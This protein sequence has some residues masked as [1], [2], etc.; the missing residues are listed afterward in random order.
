MKAVRQMDL[1]D[2]AEERLR[3]SAEVDRMV[4]TTML[5]LEMEKARAD[6][7][8][9]MAQRAYAL[10]RARATADL[11]GAAA[12]DFSGYSDDAINKIIGVPGSPVSNGASPASPNDVGVELDLGGGFFDSIDG[13]QSSGDFLSTAAEG[14]PNPATDLSEP[15]Y[16]VSNSPDETSA[17]VNSGA[18]QLPQA[19]P[20]ELSQIKAL[21]KSGD[22]TA[23]QY[24]NPLSEFKTPQEKKNPL[25]DFDAAPESAIENTLKENANAFAGPRPQKKPQENEGGVGAYLVGQVGHLQSLPDRARGL[26]GLEK[27]R[28]LKAGDEFEQRTYATTA[29][30]LGLPPA[31]G[32]NAANA[33]AY[34]TNGSQRS[35]KQI[36]EIVSLFKESQGT[37]DLLEAAAIVD[38]KSKQRIDAALGKG[39]AASDPGKDLGQLADNHKKA[40]ESFA[41]ATASGDERAI[42]RAKSLLELQE[43]QLNAA[44]GGKF[45]RDTHAGIQQNFATAMPHLNNPK[46]NYKGVAYDQVDKSKPQDNLSS[47][48][49]FVQAITEGRMPTF[50]VGSDGRPNLD[51]ADNFLKY[52]GVENTTVASY[53]KDG[54]LGLFNYNPTG[55][56]KLTAIQTKAPQPTGGEK[57]APAEG[58]PFRA[59]A[60]ESQIAKGTQDLDDEIYKIQVEMTSLAKQRESLSTPVK[61][62]FLGREFRSA[63]EEVPFGEFFNYKRETMPERD[64]EWSANQYDEIT[65]KMRELA[66]EKSEILAKRRAIKNK[67]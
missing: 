8:L 4:K 64:P 46:V 54:S 17:S 23:E 52:Y 10:S 22:K 30:M 21:A 44:T 42:A 60:E 26:K 9:T 32:A 6:I 51:A 38:G 15:N 1:D 58:N 34:G 50:T 45:R 33:L 37:M 19:G 67:K 13:R 2:A 28:F 61:E 63:R 56:K 18:A 65:A 57:P 49:F 29:K 14:F 3:E 43:E 53:K 27:S 12:L 20:Q 55:E 62:P 59:K 11:A 66:K 16:A 36:D 25:D 41:A 35:P 5:P 39:P 7:D 48:D 47:N 40:E 31:L 24:L